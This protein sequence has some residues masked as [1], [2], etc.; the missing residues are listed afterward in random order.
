MPVH[1]SPAG[2]MADVEFLRVPCP[3]FFQLL[4]DVFLDRPNNRRFHCL[5]IGRVWGKRGQIRRL[6]IVVYPY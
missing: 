6:C 4:H 5:E 2:V 1:P 3:L